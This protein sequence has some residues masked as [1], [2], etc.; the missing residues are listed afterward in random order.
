[1]GD[2]PAAHRPAAQV[3]APPRLQLPP[4]GHQGRA[5][6]GRGGATRGERDGVVDGDGVGRLLRDQGEQPARRRGRHRPGVRQPQDAPRQRPRPLQRAVSVQGQDG[7]EA[8]KLT[9]SLA[10]LQ[11]VRG[12]I[13]SAASAGASGGASPAVGVEISALQLARPLMTDAEVGE[14]WLEIDLSA[15]AT[16]GAQDQPPAQDRAARLPVQAR[17]ARS[18]P[19]R[20][21]RRRCAWRST[22]RRRRPRTLLRAQDGEP[23]RRQGDADRAG[24]PQPEAA[25]QPGARLRLAPRCPACSAVAP[26]VAAPA[27]AGRW[28]PRRR[29]S[30]PSRRPPPCLRRRRSPPS[31]RRRSLSRRPPPCRRRRHLPSCLRRRRRHLLPRRSPPAGGARARRSTTRSSDEEDDEDPP[32]PPPQRARRPPPPPPPPPAARGRRRPQRRD[33]LRRPLARLRRARPRRVS[34]RSMAHR[35]AADS[36]AADDDDDDDLEITGQHN[37]A[38]LAHARRL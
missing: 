15:W 6:L 25:P 9:V 10:A 11:A 14:I 29:R 18:R 36:A 31:R 35:R 13:A 33:R 8:G 16:R 26:A 32:P 23:A 4:D 21:R 5:R 1:M 7:A 38:Q 34:P 28:P 22:R 19:A 30:S 2:R 3:V 37:A 17:G 27:V 24:L 12:A 20:A